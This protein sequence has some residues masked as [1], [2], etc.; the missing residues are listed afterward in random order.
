MADLTVRDLTVEYS[1]AGYV[2]R[3]LDALGLEAS[4]GDLVVV[5]GPSGSGKTTL[6]SCL[7]GILSPTRGTIVAGG[8][9]VTDLQGEALARY[10]R[11][12]VGIVFQALN[13][14]PSLS[15]VE[16]VEVPLR[17]AGR[18][19]VEARRRSRALLERV[20]MADRAGSRPGHLSGGQQQR[21]AIARALAHEPTLVLAD[22]PTAHLDHIQVEGVARLLRELATP[23]RLVLVA[24]HDERITPLADRVV[25]LAPRARG[26]RRPPDRVSLAAGEVVFEQGSRGDLVYAVEEGQVEIVRIRADRTV[27]WVAAV[28]PGEYFGEL[29]PL[30]GLPRSASA[31][32]SAPA[33]LTGYTVGEFRARFGGDRLLRRTAPGRGETIPSS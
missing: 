5:L 13:L 28:G 33:V 24:T 16:N 2:I 7:G 32:T 3:P 12:Q 20:G 30:L 14:I 1:S 23:G 31:V 27:E 18:S 25:E 10:R 8:V 17:L 9:V 19:K 4:S 6:L 22:E 26:A 11:A 15:A 21:V 29:G